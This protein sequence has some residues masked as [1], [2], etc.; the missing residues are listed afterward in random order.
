MSFN[1][2]ARQRK[3]RLR[4]GNTTSGLALGQRS[5]MNPS[6]ESPEELTPENPKP[7]RRASP[8]F[9]AQPISTRKSRGRT[10]HDPTQSYTCTSKGNLSLL[11]RSWKSLVRKNPGGRHGRLLGHSNH[12]HFQ[13]SV[14]CRAQ[15]VMLMRHSVG[16]GRKVYSLR[17]SA[18]PNESWNPA[19]S[20]W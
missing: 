14:E 12:V 3:F 5:D 15:G 13:N 18:T 1:Y 19:W 2:N 9:L 16:T 10:V 7:P 4:H 6:P 17:R 20:L 8:N 11:Q